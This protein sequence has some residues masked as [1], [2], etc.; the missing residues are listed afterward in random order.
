M[1]ILIVIDYFQP[2]LGYSESFFSREFVKQGHEIVVLTSN[3]YFPFPYY[4][5]TMKKTLGERKVRIGVEEVDGIKVI[6]KKL[7]LEVFTRAFFGGHDEI[8]QDFKPEI[9]LVNKSAGF[10]AIKLAYLKD[11]YRYKLYCYDSHLLSELL[12]GHV[13]VKKIFYFLFRLLFSGILNS[14]VDKFIAVQ[15]ETKLVMR[16]YFGIKK[17]IEVIPLG[18]DTKQFKFSKLQR[19]KIRHK[20]KIATHDFVVIYTGKVIEAKGVHL[21]FQAMSILLRKYMNIKLIV[22]G[23]GT[24]RYTRYCFSLL[25]KSFS[26]SIIDIPFQPVFKLYKYYSAADIGVWPLQESTSMNDAA[27]CNLPFIANDKIGARIRISNN[28][29]LLYKQ[30]DVL[31]MV[32]K[33]EYLYKNPGIRKQMGKKGRELAEKKLNWSKLSKEYIRI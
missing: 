17:N 2:D 33:M 29:A 9:V 10:S 5:K 20:F 11:K 8:L 21:L 25:P 6:R 30:G 1:K 22:V 7:Q 13:F 27:A 4:D 18:T 15:E 24:P 19:K 31:D 32:R 3:Y 12:R 28:N 14:K 23:K 16:K 26:D